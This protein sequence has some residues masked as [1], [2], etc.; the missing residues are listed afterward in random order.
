MRD[1]AQC[2]GIRLVGG[3][4]LGARGKRSER[5]VVAGGNSFES[6]SMM[7]KPSS[8]KA[9]EIASQRT[10]DLAGT[11][12]SVVVVGIATKPHIPP[13][14]VGG[15]LV[16]MTEEER[17]RCHDCCRSEEGEDFVAGI[18]VDSGVA[19]VPVPAPV[20]VLVLVLALVLVPDS[21]SE[22]RSDDP[23]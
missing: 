3:S 2:S 19:V 23:S 17:N 9:S 10:I 11:E 6:R 1:E 8:R 15:G 4:A 5:G 7:G 22:R 18:D 20:L 12:E 16:A 14:V 21:E 13:K